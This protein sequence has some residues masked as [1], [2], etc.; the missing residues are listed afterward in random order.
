MGNISFFLCYETANTLSVSCAFTKAYALVF[1][2]A[3]LPLCFYVKS[4]RVGTSAKETWKK[5]VPLVSAIQEKKTPK[6]EIEQ[7]RSVFFASSLCNFRHKSSITLTFA[8]PIDV[9]ACEIKEVK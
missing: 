7:K 5:S 6:I 8:F 9:I 2:S 4:G 1:F 3:P